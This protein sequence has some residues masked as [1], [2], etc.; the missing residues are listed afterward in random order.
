MTQHGPVEEDREKPVDVMTEDGLHI[1]IAP[2]I[3]ESMQEADQVF[4]LTPQ[5]V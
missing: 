5:L 2:S 1:H 3:L 4:I